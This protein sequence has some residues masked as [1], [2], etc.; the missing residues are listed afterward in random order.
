[1]EE[2]TRTGNEWLIDSIADE[3][4]PTVTLVGESGNAFFII[5]RVK[6]AWERKGRN[7][8]AEEF[9]SRA[10]NGNYDNVLFMAMTYA[11]VE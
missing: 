5:G 3:D 6:R 8:V 2:T 1:M 11:D 7:D 9:V 4:K 10:T